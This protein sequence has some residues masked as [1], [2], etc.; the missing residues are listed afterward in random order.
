M[1]S[2]IYDKLPEELV[3]DVLKYT[4]HPIAEM[5][6]PAC[7]KFSGVKCEIQFNR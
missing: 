3:W 7:E 1:I 5:L 4:R 2:E 6:T